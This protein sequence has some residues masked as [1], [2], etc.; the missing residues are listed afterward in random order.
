MN[1]TQ[2]VLYEIQRALG[3]IE[4]KQEQIKDEV[5]LGLSGLREELAIHKQDDQKNFSAMRLDLQ[6]RIQER[7]RI[8]EAHN[9]HMAKIDIALRELQI[10]DENAKRLGVWILS[11]LGSLATLIG[12]AV[13]AVIKG[14]IKLKQ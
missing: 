1:V 6:E 2:E 5:R 7:E 9:L 13:L 11:A 8:M 12:G 10:E 4:G 3:R 14:Y